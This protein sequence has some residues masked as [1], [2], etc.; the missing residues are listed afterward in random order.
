MDEAIT[1]FEK[2]IMLKP[3]YAEANNNLGA[4]LFKNG[5]IQEAIMHFQKELVLTP[6]SSM[7]FTI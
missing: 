7:H 4:V 3:D 5:R 6:T 1:H 2:A